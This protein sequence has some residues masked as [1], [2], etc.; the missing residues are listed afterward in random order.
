MN[1]IIIIFATLLVSLNVYADAGFWFS[2]E[3]RG[4]FFSKPRYK[5]NAWAQISNY[6]MQ[7]CDP[8]LK[9]YVYR[10]PSILKAFKIPRIIN[11][12][13]NADGTCYKHNRQAHAR[14]STSIKD[15]EYTFGGSYPCFFFQLL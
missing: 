15:F 5:F 3:C 9:N 1:R 12:N 13:Y 2:N 11:Y 8:F 10:T 7:N 6:Q 4:S 14:A